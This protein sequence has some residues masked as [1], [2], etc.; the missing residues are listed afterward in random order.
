MTRFFIGLL[1]A[2]LLALGVVQ[3][4]IRLITLGY[5]VESTSSLR[6][7]LLDQHRVLNYNVLT[8][9]SPVIL[10][11]RLAQRDVQLA[12][13]KAIEILPPRLGVH[14]SRPVLNGLPPP[15]P[16]WWRQALK[17]GTRWFE[18]GRQAIAEPAREDR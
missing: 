17:E 16:T 15:A 10:D 6:D 8:L 9:R 1:L 12:P 3:Q 18:N 14:S 2:T 11:G 13:P 7:D 5:Q 4:R